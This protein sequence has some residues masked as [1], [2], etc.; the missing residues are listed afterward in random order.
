MNQQSSRSSDISPARQAP[1]RRRSHI[2]HP[3]FVLFLGVFPL[4]TFVAA[5]RLE[6]NAALLA[7]FD[8]AAIL[9]LA[10][11]LRLMRSSTPGD[12]R[13]HAARN[14][15]NR[16]LLLAVAAIVLGVVFISVAAELSR[17]GTATGKDVFGPLATLAL[18][19][20]FGNTVCALHYAH[21]FYDEDGNGGVQGGLTFPGGGSP[22]YVEFLYFAFTV[23]MTFQVSDVVVTASRMRRSVLGQALVAFFFAIGVL[24]LTINVAA[25]LL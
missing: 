15:A 11:T 14:D 8:A 22:T 3:I 20:S 21:L 1:R 23:G 13:A 10:L 12:I 18:A 16:G 25:G 2:S 24:A 9:F 19:W 17:T 6:W 4:G 5:S 7:G